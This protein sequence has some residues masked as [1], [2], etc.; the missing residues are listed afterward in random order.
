MYDFI[1]SIPESVGW[2]MVGALVMLDLFIGGLVSA[3]IVRSIKL[4]IEVRRE[5]KAESQKVNYRIGF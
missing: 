5:E 4:R 3:A 1:I 2:V